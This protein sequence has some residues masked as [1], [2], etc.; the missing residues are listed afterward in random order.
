MIK[1][2]SQ[3]KIE[4]TKWISYLMIISLIVFVIVFGGTLK[5]DKV[6]LTNAILYSPFLIY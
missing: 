6:P 1:I 3:N 2:I 5:L 4:E